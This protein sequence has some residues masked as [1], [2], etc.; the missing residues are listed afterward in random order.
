MEKRGAAKSETAKME[1]RKA[2][3]PGKAKLEKRNSDLL[4]ILCFC[5][6]LCPAVSAPLRL[7]GEPFLFGG[8]LAA[9]IQSS[10]EAV[11]DAVARGFDL[12]ARHNAA[13]AEAAFREAI[14]RQP[15]SQPAHRGLGLALRDEG[16][17]ADALRELQVATRLD[18][19]DA[20]AHYA[21]G[22]VAW[23][24][25]AQ[26]TPPPG[27]GEKLPTAEYR[28]LAGQELNK[29]LALRPQD[30]SLRLNLAA[31]YLDT[32]RAHEAL[33]Q[34]QEAVRLAP[35]NAAAH[36]ALGR[37]YFEEGEEEKAASEFD[38]ASRLGPGDGGAFLALGQLRFFQRKYPQAEQMFRRAI[39][40]SPDLAPAYAALARILV[41]DGRGTEARSLLE[42]AVALDPQD[43][44]S[45][46]QL[47]KLLIGAGEAGRATELLEKVARLRPDYLPAREQLALGLLRRGDFK[48]ASSLAEALIA[49]NPQAPEGHRVMALALW[50]QRDYD[51]SLAECALALSGDPGSASMLALQAIALW[52]LD[53]RKEAQSA[54]RQLAK[55]EPRLAGAGSSEIF[56]RLLVCDARD[57]GPVTEFLRK[58]RW[59]LQ[60]PQD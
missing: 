18:P 57:I 25:G 33:A 29:A 4:P 36:V 60:S 30:V 44:E 35:Q 17:W 59:L 58:N 10:K 40:V 11:A 27:A 31:I 26:A 16:K 34:A 46:F 13:G 37:V 38:A 15:E 32:G 39:Q 5:F 6:F 21:L 47:A 7:C 53:R 20:D 43:W 45:Q 52:Q 12:L 51:N 48:G 14:A 8:G 9:Q 2:A 49:Q 19:E 3:K 42:K 28:D 54:F 41:E 1:K 55:L 23:S 56:C 22:M 24:L 50:K